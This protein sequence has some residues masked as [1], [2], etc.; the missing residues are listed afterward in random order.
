MF[1]FLALFSG[2]GEIRAGRGH[3]GSR[4][5][6]RYQGQSQQP[7]YRPR[8]HRFACGRAFLFGFHGRFERPLRRFPLGFPLFFLQSRQVSAGWPVTGQEPSIELSCTAARSGEVQFGEKKRGL[9]CTATPENPA[10]PGVD[11]YP[12]AWLLP[13]SASTILEPDAV[14]ATHNICCFGPPHW[15]EHCWVGFLPGLETLEKKFCCKVPQVPLSTKAATQVATSYPPELC[16][17]YADLWLNAMT[18]RVANLTVLDSN[19]YK[20]QHGPKVLQ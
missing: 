5:S 4:S 1:D 11:P 20:G 10:D 12:S 18:S 13:A 2:F 15:K 19:A 6:A 3:L 17:E 7:R 14:Q 8:W 16:V 9:R